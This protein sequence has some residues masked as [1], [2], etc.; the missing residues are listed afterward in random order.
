MANVPSPPPPF[1]A[2]PL[3]MGNDM[4]NVTA[5]TPSHAILTNPRAIAID[6]VSVPVLTGSLT[7]RLRL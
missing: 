6:Q 3:I 1:P 5:G 7:D 2:A 4:R